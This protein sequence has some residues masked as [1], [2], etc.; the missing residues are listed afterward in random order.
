MPHFPGIA[1]IPGAST[2]TSTDLAQLQLRFQLLFVLLDFLLFLFLL[3]FDI[4]KGRGGVLETREQAEDGLVAH[5]RLKAGSLVR[6]ELLPLLDAL[7]FPV[8]LLLKLG[9]ELL[10]GIRV[11]VFAMAQS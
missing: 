10:K 9:V 2:T 3:H 7:Q 5:L 1:P 4:G 6:G 11:T 8:I